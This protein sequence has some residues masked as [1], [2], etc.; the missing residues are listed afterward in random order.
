MAYVPMRGVYPKD[1]EA[2]ALEPWRNRALSKRLRG[3]NHP[4][5]LIEDTDLA[6]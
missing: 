3:A 6:S 5:R 2:I 4:K 1:S